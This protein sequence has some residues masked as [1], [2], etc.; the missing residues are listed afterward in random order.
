MPEL[1]I[2]AAIIAGL[3]SFLSPCVLPVV[4]AYLGQLGAI[5]VS[6]RA[7]ALQAA[8]ATSAGPMAMPVPSPTGARPVTDA[9]RR[10][11]VLPHALLFVLGFGGVFTVLGTAAQYAFQGLTPDQLDIVRF[12]GGAILVVLGLNLA[13]VFRST[14]LM[15]SWRPLDAR[16]RRATRPAGTANALGAFG[17]GAVFAFGW[18]PCVGPTLGAIFALSA[19]GPSLQAAVLFGAYSLGLGVPFVLLALM[20]DRAPVITRPLVRHGRLIE[21]VGGALVVI[22][23]L[24]VMFD[25]LTFIAARFSFLNPSI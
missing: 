23:G 9:A 17:L 3:V 7:V 24:A 2:A 12:I 1:T 11:Q 22:I 25:W 21:I 18:T 16:A 19:G 10:R 8:M 5:A 15:R 6:D 13:G 4:P 20:L 14:A